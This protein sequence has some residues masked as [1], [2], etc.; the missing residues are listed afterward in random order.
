MF[1]D[2]PAPLAPSSG[3]VACGNP[4]ARRM[5]DGLC[6]GCCPCTPGGV[7]SPET[8][9]PGGPGQ[10]PSQTPSRILRADGLP[11]APAPLDGASG[12]GSSQ[13]IELTSG[14]VKRETDPLAGSRPFGQ[15]ALDGLP[16]GRNLPSMPLERSGTT[17]V[18]AGKN[19]MESPSRASYPRG[20][21]K[22]EDGTPVKMVHR[23]NPYADIPSL[24]DMYVQASAH[25]RPTERF[26][27]DV[28][29]NTTNDPQAT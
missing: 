29:R 4:S 11:P 13:N 3:S 26:G 25:Q 7:A 5:R 8:K 24:Y 28:F 21:T 9:P 19:G 16:T 18:Y 20:M 10:Q 27:L 2:E 22:A 14:S 12:A 15:G 6:E 17:P 23:V 1:S